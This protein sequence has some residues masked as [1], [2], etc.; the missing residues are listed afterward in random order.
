[1]VDPNRQEMCRVARIHQEKPEIA[2][3]LLAVA[4]ALT[5][6]QHGES[7]SKSRLVSRNG[8]ARSKRRG[9]VKW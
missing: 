6:M 5:E 4:K 3:M 9:W 7:T 2:A 1:M 8:S